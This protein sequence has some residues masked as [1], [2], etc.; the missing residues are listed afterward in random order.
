MTRDRDRFARARRELIDALQLWRMLAETPEDQR[1]DALGELVV[2]AERSLSD[3][4]EEYLQA[5]GMMGY[6]RASLS[7]QAGA[8]QGGAERRPRTS[9]MRTEDLMALIDPPTE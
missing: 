7:V 3:A 2:M 5:G 8:R 4:S 9:A 6:P 1:D